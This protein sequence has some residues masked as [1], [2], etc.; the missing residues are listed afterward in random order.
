MGRDKLCSCSC[1]LEPNPRLP[2]GSWS[3]TERRKRIVPALWGAPGFHAWL[4]TSICLF[5]GSS[6]CFK[7]AP[8]FP[9][10]RL[11]FLHLFPT[12]EMLIENFNLLPRFDVGKEFDSL[13]SPALLGAVCGANTGS[14]LSFHE[15]RHGDS[16]GQRTSSSKYFLRPKLSPRYHQPWFLP[17]LSRKLSSVS[18]SVTSTSSLYQDGWSPNWYSLGLLSMRHRSKPMPL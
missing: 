4:H 9:G 6:I 14:C 1:C 12:S 13:D 11:K 3:R 8:L 2:F 7:R 18:F 15:L 5:A 16:D 17:N 10:L